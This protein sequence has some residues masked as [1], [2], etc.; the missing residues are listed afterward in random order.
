MYEGS[1]KIG[2]TQASPAHALVLGPG[3]HLHAQASE[4]SPLKFLVIAGQPINEPIVQ[5]GGRVGG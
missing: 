3:D 2:A 5:V 1:G 4:S